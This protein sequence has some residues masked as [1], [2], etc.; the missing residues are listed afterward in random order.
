MSEKSILTKDQIEY[1]LVNEGS[2]TH[3][4]AK[5]EGERA[6]KNIYCLG[7]YPDSMYCSWSEPE[8][9]YIQFQLCNEDTAFNYVLQQMLKRFSSRYS[10][11][12]QT[13]DIFFLAKSK[14]QGGE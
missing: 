12:E 11:L 2:H 13:E 1:G 14:V 5:N 10:A 7:G 4:V 9:K 6:W 8:F 3:L